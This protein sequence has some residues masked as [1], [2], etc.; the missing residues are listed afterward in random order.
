MLAPRKVK[1]DCELLRKEM[2]ELQQGVQLMARLTQQQICDA[3]SDISQHNQLLLRRY[4]EEMKLRKTYHNELVELRGNIRVF[5]RV[6]PPIAE[7]GSGQGSTCVVHPDQD[8]D[9]R[10]L[11]DFKNRE[12]N[13]GFDRVFGAE[14]TQDEVFHEVQAL[15]TSCIDG[16]NV[17][18][19]AY[20]QTGSG[21]THT[22][23]GPSHE[24]GINQRAL[25]ELFIATDKQSDW[26]YDIRVSFLEIY[27]ESIRDLLSDRPT[28]KME[29]K[30]NAEGLLH[31]PGLTQ[32]QVNCLEDVN[33]TFTTGLENRVTASTRMNELSSRSHALLCVEVHGVNTMTS[34]KT[35]GKLN[36]VDLAGSERVSKSGADGDRLK[37][38]Q[39]INK[40]L[41]SLGDVVHALRGNQSHVPYRNSKLT[42]LLQDSLGGDSKTLMIVHVSPAQKNVGESIASLH[43][44]QRVHSVQ[45]GQ[46]TRNAVSEGSHEMAEDSPANSGR[47][48]S[49][50]AR[51]K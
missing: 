45:L 49:R 26:R 34:V 9:S 1:E 46:A 20:G 42:Y 27:N 32:I 28:T 18:I 38:A 15:V 40:S 44:G 10:L 23:Q 43:F 35:F 5:C 36:L 41:S 33:R 16:F 22:M 31:V 8:D 25:K 2:R 7:D 39:N 14:S 19:F 29:V 12:Q 3:I 48:K 30:R 24:P 11:V 21:K 37:E 6:R 47:P 51:K 13:F 50:A 17:C 4:H